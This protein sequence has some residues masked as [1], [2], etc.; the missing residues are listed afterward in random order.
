MT[1]AQLRAKAQMLV[2]QRSTDEL[3]TLFKL[4]DELL[5]NRRSM[6]PADDLAVCETRGWIIGEM[7]CRNALPLIGMTADYEPIPSWSV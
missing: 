6:L 3:V 5:R 1:A 4:T 2:E 7:E